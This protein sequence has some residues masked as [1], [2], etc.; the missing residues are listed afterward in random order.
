MFHQHYF[1][2][3][4]AAVAIHRTLLYNLNLVVIAERECAVHG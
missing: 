3:K 1:T 4:L 2:E